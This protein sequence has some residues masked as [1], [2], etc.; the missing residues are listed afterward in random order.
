[1]HGGNQPEITRIFR[2]SVKKTNENETSEYAYGVK[3]YFNEKMGRKIIVPM[4]VK[5]IF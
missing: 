5:Y 3:F 4:M 1:M 2:G